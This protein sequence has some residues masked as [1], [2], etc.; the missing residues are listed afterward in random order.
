MTIGDIEALVIK[1]SSLLCDESK[2]FPGMAKPEA[3]QLL[4]KHKLYPLKP[5]AVLCLLIK[6]SENTIL[7]D[8]GSGVDPDSNSSTLIGE[9][10]RNGVKLETIDLVILTHAHGD[11][12][13]G[14][15]DSA[16]QPIFPNARYVMAKKEWEFWTRDPDLKKY[17]AA[18]KEMIRAGVRK[19]LKSLAQSYNLIDSGG[20]VS[21]G[22]RIVMAPGHSPGHVMVE[23]TAG[24][25]KLVC[26]GDIFHHPL[27]MARPDVNTDFD[28]DPA[29]AT[30]IRQEF[31]R[32]QAR[33]K[34][35]VFAC[36]F[37][38]PGLGYIGMKD[39][40]PGWF[41]IAV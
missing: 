32:D 15:T 28:F 40:S 10:T 22:V 39:E 35:L 2:L 8:T 1:D 18:M 21:R 34:A 13:G 14:I 5:L 31:V 37:P 27:Q 9:L 16:G 12:T 11:H 7:V 30:N 26:A 41:P 38:F 4:K 20:E 36:H 29:Q 24:A 17:D 25:D 6:T 23:L 19:N 3:R 33:S